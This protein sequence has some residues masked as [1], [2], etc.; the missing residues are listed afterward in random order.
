M[1]V[2]QRP[3]LRVDDPG[4]HAAC[5]GPNTWTAMHGAET[6]F[7]NNKAAFRIGDPS[8]HCG[9]MGKLVEGSSNVIVGSAGGSGGGGGRG[10][11]WSSDGGGSGGGGGTGGGG[12]SGGGSSGGGG[13][14][15]AGASG[16]GTTSGATS[17]AIT[18]SE[19]RAAALAAAA[20]APPPPPDQ[21]D[22]QLVNVVGTPQTGIEVEVTLASGEKRAGH[23]GAD[24]HFR[25]DNIPGGGTAHVDVPDV[26]VAPPAPP[27]TP[28]RVR[29][30]E[31]G[32]SAPVGKTT[33]IELPPRVRRARMKG[34]HFETAK[35]FLLPSAMHGIRELV[36]L[37]KSFDNLVGIVNGHT[38]K[39]GPAAYNRSLSEERA[40]SIRAFLADDFGAWQKF[41]T[42]TTI[43]NAWGVREDQL[44]LSTVRQDPADSASP[45]FYTGPIDGSLAHTLPA[46]TL[47][48]ASHGEVPPPKAPTQTTRSELVKAYMALEGT[49]LPAG[50]LAPHGCGLTHPTPETKGSSNPNQP[51]NRRVE[52]FLFED[53]VDPTPQTPCPPG[54][55]AQ[56]Q[57]WVDHKILD[58][59]L[60]QDPGGLVV[61]VVDEFGPL[62]GALVHVAGPLAL[63]ETTPAS[64]E[65]RFDDL[66]PGD[67]VVIA[68]KDGLGAADQKIN[69]LPGTNRTVTLT[70]AHQSLKVLEFR[71]TPFIVQAGQK[72]KLH[73][74]VVGDFD[75]LEVRTIKNGIATGFPPGKDPAKL[76]QANDDIEVVTSLADVEDSDDHVTYAFGV[77]AKPGAINTGKNDTIR[78]VSDLVPFIDPD[79]AQTGIRR[80]NTSDH[81]RTAIIPPGEDVEFY[82]ATK[83]ATHVQI[84][85]GGI[86]LKVVQVDANGKGVVHIPPGPSRHFFLTPLAQSPGKKLNGNSSPI[87]ELV[88]SKDLTGPQ[89]IDDEQFSGIRHLSTNEHGHVVTLTSGEDAEIYWKVVNADQVVLSRQ[90]PTV[91]DPLETLAADSGDGSKQG[92]FRLVKPKHQE[93]YRLVARQSSTGQESKT[94]V[95]LIT[96][97]PLDLTPPQV[98]PAEFGARPK[99]STSLDHSTK[100]AAGAPLQF[101]WHVFRCDLVR[102][103]RVGIGTTL[104]IVAEVPTGERG[105]FD[106]VAGT[107]TK[108]VE[109]FIIVPVRVAGPAPAVGG[110]SGQF[111][112]EVE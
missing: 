59:D 82:F 11:R 41:Y 61:N 33:V 36:K 25:V 50:V 90:Q 20:N 97:V 106:T 112:I 1:I 55:C 4:V 38:D 60:D 13:K 102:I 72:V 15:N 105:T 24:G 34:L 49:S 88:V 91:T 89:I 64:G 48:Q 5:C 52:V 80:I 100:V 87:L 81:G 65:V 58:V 28:G 96:L 6:V 8:K 30:V 74:R 43:S 110:S 66:V 23:T 111:T 32:V 39:Q 79:E 44:M 31:G 56:Y 45:P 47:F 14:S 63:E 18:A 51:A 62:A 109:S 22:V 107:T 7:Y 85:A 57:I 42:G 53:V 21:L 29:Y 95:G 54:G 67:Y 101:F 37:F 68:S 69:I 16:A 35:T 104:T 99:G 9:G 17:A 26:S 93:L 12:S 10:G 2:N 71:A 108:L 78:V 92:T 3:A 27:S 94:N 98:D 70:L 77:I 75:H 86:E 46:Y 73:W 83:N 76:T 19:K 103:F 40:D 84:A